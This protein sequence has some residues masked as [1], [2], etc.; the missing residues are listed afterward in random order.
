MAVVQAPLVLSTSTH[1]LVLLLN[2]L[3]VGLKQGTMDS[4][5]A[6]LVW[7]EGSAGTAC[8]PACGCYLLGSPVVSQAGPGMRCTDTDRPVQ[9]RLPDGTRLAGR[10]NPTQT[11][12]DLRRCA[13]PCTLGRSST[14]FR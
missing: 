6:A 12:G 2:W 8:M 3:A 7:E 10:F 11:V 9:V 1:S 4:W 5:K 13:W 14:S